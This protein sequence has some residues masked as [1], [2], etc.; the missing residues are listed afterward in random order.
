MAAT[1]ADAAGKY[2]GGQQWRVLSEMHC[3]KQKEEADKNVSRPVH[4][5]DLVGLRNLQQFLDRQQRDQGR[6]QRQHRHRSAQ[7]QQQDNRD[8]K[9]GGE[10]SFQ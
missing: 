8:Q 6:D 9:H 1:N 4:R 10:N 3:Q 5:P 7:H 2:G